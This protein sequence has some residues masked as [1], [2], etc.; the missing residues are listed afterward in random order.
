MD[1]GFGE[2]LARSGPITAHITGAISGNGTSRFRFAGSS[3]TFW[4]WDF[5]LWDCGG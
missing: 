3:S 5:K 4:I 1:L 2:S